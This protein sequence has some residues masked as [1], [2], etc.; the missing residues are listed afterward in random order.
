M[1]EITDRIIKKLDQN[2]IE[3]GKEFLSLAYANKILKESRI[4]TLQ[5]IEKKTLKNLLENETIKNAIKTESKPRQWRILPS[6][7]LVKNEIR[8]RKFNKHKEQIS[9]NDGDF[10]KDYHKKHPGFKFIMIVALIILFFYIIG[11]FSTPDP[12]HEEFIETR[13]KM[14]ML[15]KK[16]LVTDEDIK[17]YEDTY[18]E[19]R[20][21]KNK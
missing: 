16:G 2:M 13:A 6:N 14:M 9:S 19:S 3:T 10:W 12:E 17:Q 18:Y 11:K 4:L 8:E 7:D 21:N 1:K 5:E 20:K 15:K